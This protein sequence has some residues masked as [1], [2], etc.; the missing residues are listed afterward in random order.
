MRDDRI[1]WLDGLVVGVEDRMVVADPGATRHLPKSAHV[2]VSHAHSDHTGGFRHRGV[3]QSTTETRDIHYALNMVEILNFQPLCINDGFTLDNVEVRAL[4]A[5]HM[6]GSAQFLINTPSCSVLYTGDLNFVDTLT[7]R[8]AEP[9]ECDI[10]VMEAT[11]GSPRYR[12]PSRESVYAQIVEWAIDTVKQG[13]VPCLHV[14]AAG[15]AQEV[16]KLFNIYTKLPVVVSPRL[17]HVNNACKMSGLDLE[18]YPGE[19][20]DGKNILDKDPCVYLTTTFDPIRINRKYSR[21]YATGWALSR[22]FWSGNSFPLSSHADFDQLSSY[23]K[24]C[25]PKKVYI[26][27]GFAREFTHWVKSKLG[28]EA[29]SVPSY[30][31]RSLKE[32]Y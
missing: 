27:T 28:V 30:V 8:A 19:S 20:R 15:K 9:H 32:A 5:G 23:V 1:G 18:W 14:Y 17:D 26:F 4:N 12:F 3:K 10:L 13:R 31:Q 21:A 22:H 11:Y 25:R 16:V 24:A 2:L 29:R 6:W 7:T